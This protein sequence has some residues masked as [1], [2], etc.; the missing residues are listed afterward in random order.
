MCRAAGGK[1]CVW[2]RLYGISSRDVA[3]RMYCLYSARAN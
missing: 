1:Y 3:L 2:L